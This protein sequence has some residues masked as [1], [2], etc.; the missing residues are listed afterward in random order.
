MVLNLKDINR[1]KFQHFPF[2]LVDQSPWPILVSFALLSL[3]TGAVMH[4]HGI[5]NSNIVFNLG[6]ILTGFGMIL[7]FRDIIIEGA[8]LGNHTKEVQ[9]GLEIGVLLFI[10]SEVFAFLSVFWAFLHASLAPA[11][12]IGAQW[13]PRGIT[14]LD[15]FAVPL[16]NTVILLSSGALI[17]YGHHALILGN[18]KAAILGVILTVVFAVIF[19]GLQYMEYLEATFTITD[20]V[21]GTVFYSS[22]GLHGLH[23]II[24]TL[25]ILVGLARLINY[26][27]TRT[28]HVGLGSA[29]IYWH[30][31]DIVWL[32][33]FA[34]V[35]YWTGANYI[36]FQ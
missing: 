28:H 29:I 30:F 22:T 2:H 14:P 34:L 31:V 11:I 13:P 4:F 5:I 36:S 32:F 23:V 25:F 17:T 35:Y 15:P 26:H 16:L 21:F 19:T 33:L 27:F 9:K 6:F 24:G 12:E 20:S 3:T 18:R 1:S 8:L 7:W 10:V